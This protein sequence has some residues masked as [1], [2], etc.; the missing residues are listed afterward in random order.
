[1]N[2][3]ALYFICKNVAY[4]SSFQTYLPRLTHMIMHCFEVQRVII[5][6]FDPAEQLLLVKASSGHLP[7]PFSLTPTQGI[8]IYIYIYIYSH[9]GLVGFAFSRGTGLHVENAYEDPRFDP[10]I[11]K[12]RKSITKNI[13]IVPIKLNNHC[14][15]CLE[16]ANKLNAGTFSASNLKALSLISLELASGVFL[17]AQ[18]DR[19]QTYRAKEIEYKEQVAQNTKEAFLRPL[20]RNYMKLVADIYYA[21]K[22]I[23]IYI[24]I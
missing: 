12:L 22:Y 4:N 8:Y 20:I 15:G 21:D 14:I 1:M 3:L 24:Y 6:L 9:L 2:T 7:D 16:V 11:D 23:Y 17:F 10:N 5:Y 18:R 13:V 19:I